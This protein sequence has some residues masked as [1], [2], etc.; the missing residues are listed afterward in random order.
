MLEAEFY[1]RVESI[2]GSLYCK[3][4]MLTLLKSDLPLASHRHQKRGSAGFS[5]KDEEIKPKRKLK[6]NESDLQPGF[7]WWFYEYFCKRTAF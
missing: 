2:L 7:V 4:W 6:G 3:Q 1:L 5:G